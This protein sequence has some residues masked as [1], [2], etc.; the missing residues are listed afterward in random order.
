MPKGLYAGWEIDTNRW[1]GGAWWGSCGAGPFYFLGQIVYVE[2]NSQDLWVDSHDLILSYQSQLCKVWSYTM[3]ATWSLWLRSPGGISPW[4]HSRRDT[5]RNWVGQQ[6]MWSEE[7]LQIAIQNQSVM[8]RLSHEQCEESCVSVLIS[9]GAFVLCW[10][11]KLIFLRIF[12]R[13]VLPNS[14]AQLFCPLAE[15]YVIFVQCFGTLKEHSTTGNCSNAE[16]KTHRGLEVISNP[17]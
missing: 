7:H 1:R 14:W 8:V 9:A 17:V 5:V 3:T 10:A 12:S 6:H 2:V 15:V 16:V 11:G 4:M 13:C